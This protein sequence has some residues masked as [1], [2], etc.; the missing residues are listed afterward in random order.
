MNAKATRKTLCAAFKQFQ[1]LPDWPSLRAK[2]RG[3]FPE[4]GD[5]QGRVS[6]ILLSSG[7]TTRASNFKVFSRM[8]R[9]CNALWTSHIQSS[10]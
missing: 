9:Y 6:D 2:D 8:S 7:T 10:E 1:R 3:H 5:E 4:Q